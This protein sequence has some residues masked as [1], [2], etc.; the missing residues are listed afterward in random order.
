MKKIT[1]MFVIA[2]AMLFIGWD[3]SYAD[4][5]LYD[6]FDDGSEIINPNRWDIQNDTNI[7]IT[8]E[9]GRAKFVHNPNAGVSNSSFLVFNQSP[10]SIKAVKLKLSVMGPCT[11]DVRGRVAGWFGKFRH[12]DSYE[13]YSYLWSEMSL[14]TDKEVISG[15]CYMSKHDFSDYHKLFWGKL[16]TELIYENEYEITISLPNEQQV[17]YSMVDIHEPRGKMTFTPPKEVFPTDD[18]FKGIGTISETG[19]GGCVVFFDEV[20]VLRD[21]DCQDINL[22]HTYTLPCEGMFPHGLAFDGANFWVVNF[23]PGEIYKLQLNEED[24]SSVAID[25]IDMTG[26]AEICMGLTFEG[27]NLWV[28]CSNWTSDR[29]TILAESK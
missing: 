23:N 1:L 9:D 22:V 8:I 19:E 17:T 12:E 15:R 7:S 14:E 28:P 10:E 29:A 11:G 18:H 3:V 5:Y 2:F 21:E 4:W 25:T 6:N 16:W 27:K 13:P 26:E 24:Y 20:Y